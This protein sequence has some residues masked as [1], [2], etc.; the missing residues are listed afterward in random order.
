MANTYTMRVGAVEVIV[1]YCMS[2]EE[3]T[4]YA[5]RSKRK[6]GESNVR[7]VTLEVNGNAVEVRT[8]LIREPRER[9]KRLSPEMVSQ[10]TGV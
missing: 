10:Y 7:G 1:P 6:F 9:L 3:A 4:L 2:K 5:D 8:T